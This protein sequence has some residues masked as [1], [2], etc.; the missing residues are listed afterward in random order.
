M[1]GSSRNAEPIEIETLA[2]MRGTL[3]S[4]ARKAVMAWVTANREAI[5]AEWNRINVRFPIA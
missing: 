3:P 2:V 4:S 1:R 5:A